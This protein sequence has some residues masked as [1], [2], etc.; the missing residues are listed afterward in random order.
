MRVPTSVGLLA[1]ALGGALGA[2]ARFGL[3]TA[4]P[5]HGT[6]FPWTVFGINVAGSVALAALGLTP[7]VPRT[8]WLPVFLGTGVMGGFTTMSA[9]SGDTFRLLDAG[10]LG[11]GL[12]YAAGTLVAA[13][14]LAGL[15]VRVDVPGER[16]FEREEGDE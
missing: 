6:D 2:L 7:V 12:A 1:A 4:F 3:T 5:A 10:A 13:L 15:V 14:V 9:A 11:T 16:G 8:P